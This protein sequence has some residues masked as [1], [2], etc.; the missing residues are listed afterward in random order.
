MR[1]A[2]SAEQRGACRDHDRSTIGSRVATRRCSVAGLGKTARG[3]LDHLAARLSTRYL[4]FISLKKVVGS[5]RQGVARVKDQRMA[6]VSMVLYIFHQLSGTPRSALCY[7]VPL[8]MKV[9]KP[10]RQPVT[11]Q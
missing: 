5:R 1:R 11:M 4:C 8:I 6:N 3:V 2:E 7:C 10:S 9:W